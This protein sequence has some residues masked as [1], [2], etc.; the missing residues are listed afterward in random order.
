MPENPLKSYSLTALTPF[1]EISRLESLC[2]S[3]KFDRVHLL[4]GGSRTARETVLKH[5]FEA[6]MGENFSPT[7][8]TNADTAAPEAVFWGK[9]AVISA[10]APHPIE[11]KF[12]TAFENIIWLGECFDSKIL[13]QRLGELT[14]LTQLAQQRERQALRLL[15][16]AWA[17]M[18]DSRRMANEAVN[19]EKL[20]RQAKKTAPKLPSGEF[21]E[22]SCIF[23]SCFSQNRRIGQ[24]EKPKTVIV[25]QDELGCCAPVLLREVYSRAKSA[26]C[27]VIAGYSPYSPYERLEQLIL[28][29]AGIGIF[30]DNSRVKCPFDPDHVIHS[31]RFTDRERISACKNRLSLNKK[32]AKQLLS[33]AERLFGEREQLLS[34]TDAVYDSALNEEALMKICQGII[35]DDF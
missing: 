21:S 35:T 4:K 28:P 13:R 29:Q 15:S 31:R 30:T 5:C 33:A 19:G 23:S 3:R 18:S 12:P 22:T 9:T 8:I 17:L 11:P 6:A 24:L 20:L 16:S 7:M 25:L 34:Q 27:E 26:G 1:G 32:A 10:A 14:E 2:D